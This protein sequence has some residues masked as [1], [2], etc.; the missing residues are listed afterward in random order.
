M[1]AQPRGKWIVESGLVLASVLT[2]VVL[3]QIHPLALHVYGVA[4]V[5]AC[6]VLF[7]IKGLIPEKRYLRL[8]REDLAIL[9]RDQSQ[10]PL[11][12]ID[13]WTGVA[14]SLVKTRSAQPLRPNERLPR[15]FEIVNMLRSKSEGRVLWLKWGANASVLVGLAGTLLGMSNLVRNVLATSSSSPVAGKLAQQGA[16]ALSQILPHLADMRDMFYC[17]LI[18]VLGSI[19]LSGLREFHLSD[20]ETFFGELEIEL[21]SVIPAMF[22]KWDYAN[23]PLRGI[24]V[25]AIR[26][27]RESTT[28]AVVDG[29]TRLE[30]QLSPAIVNIEAA[31]TKAIESTVTSVVSGVERRN[32]EIVDR[33]D[34]IAAALTKSSASSEAWVRSAAA[35]SADMDRVAASMRE[36]RI[37]LAESAAQFREGSTA[38]AADQ[39]TLAR[40]ISTNLSTGY[41]ELEQGIAASVALYSKS[42]SRSADQLSNSLKK[43]SDSEEKMAA[44]LSEWSRTS[45]DYTSG[46]QTPFQEL[47]KFRQS[48]DEIAE[49]FRGDMGISA[50]IDRL[51]AHAAQMERIIKL[52]E[53]ERQ[54][55]LLALETEMKVSQEVHKRS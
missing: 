32:Q 24:V 36:A 40:E 55:F 48:L 34:V 1:N 33:L 11:A 2:A 43:L 31:M 12:G 17:S 50:S 22:P 29:A 53:Q 9:R 44:M 51:S 38:L 52:L 30:S 15:P 6:V 25:E 20:L 45:V 16:G 39:A 37:G 23:D 54:E 18:G 13:S 35:L 19:A 3:H 8:S 42:I 4:V 46:V 21:E 47:K 27:I 41:R 10:A 26:D 7:S 28:Q 49:V 5:V 14:F